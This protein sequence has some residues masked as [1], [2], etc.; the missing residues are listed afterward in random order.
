MA[1]SKFVLA[2]AA[3]GLIGS[4]ALADEQL[5]GRILKIDQANG[6]IVLEHK[7]MGTVGAAGGN[8]LVDEYSLQNEAVLRTLQVGDAV[9]F[10]A[11]QIGGTWAVTGIYKQ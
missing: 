3:A 7:P 8:A 4:A 1:I 10:T 6:K 9:N 5:T 11:A 2:A